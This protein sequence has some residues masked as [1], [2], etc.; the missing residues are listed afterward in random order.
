MSKRRPR[1]QAIYEKATQVIPGGVNSPVRAFKGLGVD[2][3]IV[4]KGKGALI[5][6]ADGNVYIDYCC[7]WGALIHGHNPD[8]LIKEVKQQLENGLSFGISTEIEME[9]ATKIVNILPS[10]EMVRFVSSG[11]EAVMSAT[12]LARAVTG[13]PVIIKFEG[14]Y[15]GHSDCL[16]IKAGSGVAKLPEASSQGVTFDMVKQTLCL[17]FN[18]F[19]S[20][21]N[22][23]RNRQDIAAV[24]LEPVTANMGVVLPESGFLEMLRE[25]TEKCGA[26]LIF[27]EVVTGFRLGLQGAQGYFGID[28]DLTCL[29]KVIGGGFPAAAYGGKKR[30]M[31]AMAPLGNVYQ[32]GT[33]SGFPLAMAA[34]IAAIE[35]VE[36]PG[37]YRNLEALTKRL[38]EPIEAYVKDHSLPVAVRSL[39][40]M[41][42]LFFGVEE[43]KSYSDLKELDPVAFKAFFAHML[44]RGIYLPPSQV[45]AW[46]VS[47]AHTKEQIDQTVDAVLDFL[48][49]YYAM[50]YSQPAMSSSASS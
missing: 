29:G 14:H 10:V 12:R 21:R 37:F 47:S 30:W 50:R 22:V 7:S 3:M 20:C 9:I 45:E 11:T 1:A 42:T 36:R 2:P 44:E 48:K 24:L 40:S 16:L 23:L 4:E 49:N 6:D 35:G 46:F 15:H 43:V 31:Q 32:A 28:P 25:E 27:D 26:L 41:V 13:K 34:G 5:E 8:F 33:L 17:P 19:E 38:V 18:D 39:G